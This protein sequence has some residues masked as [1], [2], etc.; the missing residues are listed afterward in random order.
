[1]LGGVILALTDEPQPTTAWARGAAGERQVGSMLDGLVGDD[2]VALDDRRIPRSRANIDHLAVVPSGVWVIDAERYQGQVATKD[3][4]SLVLGRHAPLRRPPGLHEA[5][6]GHGPPG[7]SRSHYLGS[8]WADVPVHPLVSLV[9]AADDASPVTSRDWELA[10]TVCASRERAAPR[11]G[12]V[13]GCV[14]GE[15]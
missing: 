3:V 14:D 12:A 4:G 8:D 10:R 15:D 2:V 5:H 11:D 9:D 1:V 7:G 13:R 6:R